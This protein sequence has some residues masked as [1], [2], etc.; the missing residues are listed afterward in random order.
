MVQLEMD[1]VP[2]DIDLSHTA[3]LIIDMQVC[4]EVAHSKVH[5]Y[6]TERVVVEMERR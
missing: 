3:L 2:G 4:R 6:C 1:P 5:C